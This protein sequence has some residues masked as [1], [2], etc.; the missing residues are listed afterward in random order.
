[1][2]WISDITI[3]KLLR[4]HFYEAFVAVQSEFTKCSSYNTVKEMV[5][6]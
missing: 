3:H 1:M 6:A 2:Q 5:C 4:H